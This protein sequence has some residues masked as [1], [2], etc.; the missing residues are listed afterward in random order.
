MR[1]L[2]VHPKLEPL[3]VDH[4]QPHIVRRCSVEDA[5]EHRVDADR[6]ASARRSCNEQVR[7]GRQ[8]GHVWFAV[9]R[10]AER[11]G[12][13]RGRT[14]IGV[15]LE[16]FAQ[17][18]LLAR[19]VGNLDTN[20]R[21]ARNAIDQ[22]RFRL[23]RQ[24]EIVRE[25]RDL[26]VLH[27]GVRL[28]LVRRDDWTRVNLHDRAF[29]RKLAALLLEETRGIHQFPFVDLAFRFRCVQQ[30]NGRQH[31]IADAPF[32]WR[33][34]GRLDV[35]QRQGRR[36]GR[37]SGRSLG[38]DRLWCRGRRNS[39]WWRLALLHVTTP[40]GLQALIDDGIH[41]GDVGAGLLGVFRDDIAALLVA[42]PV[43]TPLPEPGEQRAT[44]AEA[45]VE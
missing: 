21:L 17:R 33:L 2:L 44:S 3:G 25:P 12:Q 30:R 29:D 15:G 27:A 38:N 37:H 14:P 20:G 22:H 26:R 45:C 18:D 5:R 13:L 19:V 16:Q 10:L 4:D 39:L 23:H 11:N 34:G 40:G 32:R 36:H 8:V 9:N 42:L 7:H 28:E 43:F 41:G 6:F 31:V 35:D 1:N 24:A